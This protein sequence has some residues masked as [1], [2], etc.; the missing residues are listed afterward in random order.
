MDEDDMDENEMNEN[1]LFCI[2]CGEFVHVRDA[3]IFKGH[4]FCSEKCKIAGMP[5][6]DKREKESVWYNFKRQQK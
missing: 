6:W 3:V 2:E 4:V 1:Y 5:F